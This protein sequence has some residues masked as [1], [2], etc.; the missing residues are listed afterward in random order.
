MQG[1]HWVLQRAV[2]LLSAISM[3]LFTFMLDLLL[4]EH[5]GCVTTADDALRD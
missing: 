3:A 4:L 2:S 5:L 1:L